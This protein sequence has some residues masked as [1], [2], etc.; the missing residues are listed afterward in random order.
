MKLKNFFSESER[1]RGTINQEKELQEN[2]NE[3]LTTTTSVCMHNKVV[4]SSSRE[5]THILLGDGC[6]K[7]KWV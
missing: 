3:T 1:E 6:N 4:Y 2:G 7:L 5:Q